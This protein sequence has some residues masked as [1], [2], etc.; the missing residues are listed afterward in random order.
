MV[1]EKSAGQSPARP[2]VALN[3]FWAPHQCP[4]MAQSLCPLGGVPQNPASGQG[5]PKRGRGLP[6]ARTPPKGG[7]E[8]LVGIGGVPGPLK[9]P[10]LSS[11]G[12]HK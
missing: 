9:P 7:A 10:P 6:E 2:T 11:P 3:P 5:G 8:H 1:P 4:Q 12:S